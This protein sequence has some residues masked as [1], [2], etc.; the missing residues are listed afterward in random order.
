MPELQPLTGGAAAPHH[1]GPGRA[2]ALTGLVGGQGYSL[3]QAGLAPYATLTGL[4]QPRRKFPMSGITNLKTLARSEGFQCVTEL[5]IEAERQD[6]YPSVCTNEG[7]ANFDY[8][9]PDA[10]SG[11]CEE[12]GTNTLTSG[13]RLM[14]LI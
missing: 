1:R 9:E 3:S 12:C 11:W 6:E 5:L 10:E 8:L 4:T 13:L 14:G 7:C 2:S